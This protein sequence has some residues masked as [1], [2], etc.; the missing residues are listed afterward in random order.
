MTNQG[1]KPGLFQLKIP[2]VFFFTLRVRPQPR[3]LTPR[4]DESITVWVCVQYARDE[5]VPAS[6]PFN[7]D[8]DLRSL[9]LPILGVEGRHEVNAPVKEGV[10]H[11][12]APQ[13]HLPLVGEVHLVLRKG[14]A[15]ILQHQVADLARLPVPLQ[16]LQMGCY[17][18]QTEFGAN[19]P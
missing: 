11:E 18:I 17:S 16:R 14:A 7:A 19:G 4:L 13:L 9:A 1:Q 5:D 10:D 3:R 2:G 6:T 12:D 15:H 8:S